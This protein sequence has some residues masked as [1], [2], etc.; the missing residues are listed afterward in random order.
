[1]AMHIS[2][3]LIAAASI[4][5]CDDS[6]RQYKSQIVASLPITSIYRLKTQ[7]YSIVNE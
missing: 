7:L 4:A 3:S 5:K 6:S 1:M 2:H